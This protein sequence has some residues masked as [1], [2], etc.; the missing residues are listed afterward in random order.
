[1]KAKETLKK[2]GELISKN[3]NLLIYFGG[4]CGVVYGCMNT[5]A[6]IGYKY[7]IKDGAIDACS[8]AEE[9]QPGITVKMG[10]LASKKLAEKCN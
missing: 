9:I 6:D 5:G 8:L 1:M 4:L 10:E 3:K 7:G 2:A